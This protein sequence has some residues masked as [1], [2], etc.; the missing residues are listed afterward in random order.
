MPKAESIN[1]LSV[2]LHPRSKG[3]VRLSSPHPRDPLVVDPQYLSCPADYASL[4]SSIRLSLRVV[5]RMRARGYQISG[6]DG[7]TGESDAELDKYVQKNSMTTYHYSSTCRMA[8]EDDA[9]GGGVVDDE[10]RVHGVKGLRVADASVFPWVVG[11]HLQ[12]PTV[13]VAEKCADLVLAA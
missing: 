3:T 11:T 4:R 2:L 13:M 6:W 1:L 10:L 9:E 8:P 7:P 5:E 12:A